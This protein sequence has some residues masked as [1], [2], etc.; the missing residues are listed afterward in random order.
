MYTHTRVSWAYKGCLKRR[1]GYEW[2]NVEFSPTER[3][4][5]L[6]WI[7]E[8]DIE[9]A[10]YFSRHANCAPIANCVRT[11]KI[12][13]KRRDAL[14][15]LSLIIN[16]LAKSDEKERRSSVYRSLGTRHRRRCLSHDFWKHLERTNIF[17]QFHARVGKQTLY[18]AHGENGVVYNYKRR[19]SV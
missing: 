6:E 9:I 10:V 2:N 8:R 7:R 14:T 16:I 17:E 3:G 19:P 18:P 5:R 11:L 12:Y 1:N 15:K 4:L 13:R